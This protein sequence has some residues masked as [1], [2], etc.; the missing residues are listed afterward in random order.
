LSIVAGGIGCKGRD[1]VDMAFRATNGE[2]GAR[3]EI[4]AV[5][6]EQLPAFTPTASAR[7]LLVN[8]E[9]KA[10]LKVRNIARYESAR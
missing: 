9:G 4:S 7:I 8:E 2:S 10:E 6:L 1:E 5:G 3:A